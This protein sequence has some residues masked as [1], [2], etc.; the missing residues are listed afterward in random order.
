MGETK[1][2]RPRDRCSELRTASPGYLSHV[3]DLVESLMGIPGAVAVARAYIEG[4]N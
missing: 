1:W 2:N 3:A 4:F